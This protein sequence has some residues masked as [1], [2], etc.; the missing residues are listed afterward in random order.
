MHELHLEQERARFRAGLV[1]VRNVMDAQDDVNEARL[2]ALV[3]IRTT[4][5][6]AVQL[7]RLEGSLLDAHGIDWRVEEEMLTHVLE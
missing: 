6:A 2:R 5:E 4:I 7:A 3:A 1:T